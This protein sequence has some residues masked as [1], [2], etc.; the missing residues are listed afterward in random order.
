MPHLTI[1]YSANLDDRADIGALC[2]TLRKTVLE[3]GLFELG[4]VRVRAL[5]ADH[6]AIADQLPENAFVDLNFRIGK[7]RTAE[8]KKGTGEA[9][10]AAAADVLGPLFET[11]HFALSLE[12]REIDAELS[13]KKNAIHPRLRG[14]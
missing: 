10:F 12:I 4:A 7:G 2:E 14:K 9:I 5:R 8:E 3:T 1:E 13:W 11:P 6:Y